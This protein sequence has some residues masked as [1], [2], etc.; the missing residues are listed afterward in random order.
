MESTEF[1]LFRRS[2]KINLPARFVMYL[3]QMRSRDMFR[4]IHSCFQCVE[5][6]GAIVTAQEIKGFEKQSFQLFNDRIKHRTI[7][8]DKKTFFKTRIVYLSD[9]KK[10]SIV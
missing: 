10:T 7:G 2:S 4:Q 9:R 1:L 3:H 5:H 6:L 8:C